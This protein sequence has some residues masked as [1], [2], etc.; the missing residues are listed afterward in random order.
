MM[1]RK[2]AYFFNYHVTFGDKKENEYE[3]NYISK[4]TKYEQFND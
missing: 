1:T 4:R 2:V 3:S